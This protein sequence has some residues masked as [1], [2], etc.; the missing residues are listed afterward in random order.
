MTRRYLIWVAL[1]SAVLIGLL[2]QWLPLPDASRRLADLPA[3]GPGFTGRDLP[4]SGAE[5]SVFEGATVLKR[6][7]QVGDRRFL[8]TVIDGTRRRQAIH[9]PLYCLRGAGWQVVLDQPTVLPGGSARWIQASRDGVHA[10][11]LTWFTDGRLRHG[12]I[13]RYWWQTTLRRLSLGRS[14]P[15]PLLVQ[16]Q[17]VGAGTADWG[18]LLKEMPD[19]V[20]L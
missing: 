5:S 9:D 14:G 12:S 10:E 1:V 8:L 13:S 11:A 17:P 15:E 16:L 18:R 2:W 19:L 6:L 7:Y 4:L 20:R 3:N